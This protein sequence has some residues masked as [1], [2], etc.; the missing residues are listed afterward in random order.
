M[1]ICSNPS[2]EFKESTSTAAVVREYECVSV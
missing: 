2:C 1:Q